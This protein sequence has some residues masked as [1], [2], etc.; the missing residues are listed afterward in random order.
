MIFFSLNFNSNTRKIATIKAL[1]HAMHVLSQLSTSIGRC[2]I[3]DMDSCRISAFNK[4]GNIPQYIVACNVFIKIIIP[5]MVHLT[6]SGR[7]DHML[8]TTHETEQGQ[9]QAYIFP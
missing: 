7:S 3:P 5:R 9:Q 2:S 8:E 6:R 1:R 4:M